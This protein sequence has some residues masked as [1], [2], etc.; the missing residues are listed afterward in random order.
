MPTILR[1]SGFSIRIYTRDHAPMR[2]HVFYQ[3]NEAIIEFEERVTL[4]NNR[5]LNRSQLKR[6]MVIVQDNQEILRQV[7]REL[8]G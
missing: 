8:Y 7:W 4:R 1:E 2:V 6:A 3:G 5:G